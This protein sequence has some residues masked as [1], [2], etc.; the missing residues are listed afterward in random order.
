MGRARGCGKGAWEELAVSKL[1]QH[2]GSRGKFGE[3]GQKG[4]SPG[5][6]DVAL[7]GPPGMGPLSIQARARHWEGN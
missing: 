5:Q 2:I 4:P 7:R 1:C 6:G 3:G